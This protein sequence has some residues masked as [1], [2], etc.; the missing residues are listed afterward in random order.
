MEQLIKD[1]APNVWKYRT[2]FVA[3]CENTLQ[4]FLIAGAISFVL[5]LIVFL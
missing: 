5:G 1:W 4:M 3:Q 2:K